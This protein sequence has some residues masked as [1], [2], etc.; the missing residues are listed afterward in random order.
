MPVQLARWGHR[1]CLELMVRKVSKAR[2][3]PKDRLDHKVRPA[4]VCLSCRYSQ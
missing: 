3:D 4:W 1:A 2:W